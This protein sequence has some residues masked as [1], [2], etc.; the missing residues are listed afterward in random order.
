MAQPGRVAR[1]LT[2]GVAA[3]VCLLG[4]RVVG[5]SGAPVARRAL[6]AATLNGIVYVAGGWN[7]EATQLARVD[8]YD[9]AMRAWQPAPPLTIARSQH[10]LVA[11]LGRLWAVA[12]WSAERGLVA[13]VETWGPG[14]SSWR[15]LTRLPTPRREP[16]VALLGNRIVVAGGFNGAS[17][18]DLDGYSG[19]VEAYDLTAGTWASLA[20]L[21]TPR[22]GLVLVNLDGALY[23]LGGFNAFDGFL[24]VVER[25]D[26][27]RNAWERLD[28]AIAPR[29]WAAGLADGAGIVLIGGF[30][31]SGPLARVERI[32]A[33]SGA[34]C[35]LAP[36]QVARSWLAA[37]PLPGGRAVTVGGETRAG[38]SDA[39]EMIALGDPDAAGDRR[40]RH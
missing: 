36:L 16:G 19:V 4:A 15:T 34:R 24:G 13:E 23:A 18:A 2:V 35:N 1:V 21:P 27:S 38:F 32:E 39:V 12:G 17:D 37:V 20:S 9:P 11:A 7:G 8:A 5:A 40:C 6:A 31:G 30:D 3:A 14:E 22:R 28:W 33:R 26:P 25:Y 10:S 29:T